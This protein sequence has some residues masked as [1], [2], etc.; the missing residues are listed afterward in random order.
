MNSKQDLS[1]NNY[2]LKVLGLIIYLIA[3]LFLAT[4]LVKNV[5][6]RDINLGI[7]GLVFIIISLSLRWSEYSRKIIAKQNKTN[8]T[9]EKKERI[10]SQNTT[11][12]N[13]SIQIGTILLLIFC[14]ITYL[15]FEKNYQFSFICLDMERTNNIGILVFGISSLVESVEDALAKNSEKLLSKIS[16]GVFMIFGILYIP[17]IFF[18]PA[19]CR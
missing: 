11:I 18:G 8:S 19:F 13:Y 3:I 6:D 10:T 2:W 12:L 14:L 15:A 16:Q 7:I 5:L 4:G 17:L 1:V 9:E